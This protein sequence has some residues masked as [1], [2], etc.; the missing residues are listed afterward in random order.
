MIREPVSPG[1]DRLGVIA[2]RNRPLT[3]GTA[4]LHTHTKPGRKY[5][6]YSHFI[7]EEELARRRS[8]VGLGS[9]V[10]FLPETVIVLTI[11]CTPWTELQAAFT[12]GGV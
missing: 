5:N 1:R 11:M 12:A 4:T 3:N 2:Q 7:K 9:L 10:L 8:R 6:A